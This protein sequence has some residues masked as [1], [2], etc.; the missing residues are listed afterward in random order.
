MGLQRHQIEKAIQWSPN[1]P[2]IVQSLAS[3]LTSQSGEDTS[4]TPYTIEPNYRRK[5]T[6]D[7]NVRVEVKT[8]PS[9]VR[10]RVMSFVKSLVHWWV[11]LR[12]VCYS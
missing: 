2:V 11:H 6:R 1:S 10:F 9:Q 5:E 4:K 3:S 12:N 8:A 7:D